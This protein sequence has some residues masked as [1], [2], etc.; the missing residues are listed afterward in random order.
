MFRMSRTVSLP[1]CRLPW[2]SLLIVFHSLSRRIVAD[3]GHD[4]PFPLT[5][6]FIAVI[7]LAF[8]AGVQFSVSELRNRAMG[9]RRNT[10]LVTAVSGAYRY[11]VTMTYL[12]LWM[13]HGI[14]ARSRPFLRLQCFT[15][16]VSVQSGVSSYCVGWLCYT[17][18]SDRLESRRTK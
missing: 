10:S 13:D 18:P 9:L 5:T 8:C 12:W 7:M 14:A 1:W 2:L 16:L 15:C 17:V 4:W 11:Y 6:Q 3:V